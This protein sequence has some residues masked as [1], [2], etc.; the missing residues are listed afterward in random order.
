MSWLAAKP[1]FV[2]W[3]LICWLG[4]SPNMACCMAWGIL[5]LVPVQ[6]C[7]GLCPRVAGCGILGVLGLA[8][9]NLWLVSP[10]GL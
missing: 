7:V 5:V 8:L 10:W 2:W 9:V 1:C 6:W 4:L 3:L